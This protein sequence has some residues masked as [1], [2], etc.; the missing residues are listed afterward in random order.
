MNSFMYTIFYYSSPVVLSYGAA[1]L[2]IPGNINS[3]KSKSEMN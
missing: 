3:A 1:G 2:G